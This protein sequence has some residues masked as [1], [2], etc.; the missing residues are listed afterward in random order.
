[1]LLSLHGA[2]PLPARLASRGLPTVLGGR[3]VGPVDP[4]SEFCWVDPDNAGG[5]RAAVAHLIAAGR[6]RIA[7][8]AGP[9]DMAVGIERLAGYRTALAAAGRSDG[10]AEL[11]VHGDFSEASGAAATAE[12]L[13]RVP[14]LDAIFAASDLMALGAVRALRQAGRA[15]PADVGVVG[16]DDSALAVQ[17]DPPLTTVHQPVEAMGRA[18][19]RTLC[20]LINGE[21]VSHVVLDTHLVLRASG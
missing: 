19:A 6:R 18:M 16:F 4:Q 10:A 21:Q 11:V 17:V 13:A 7:H 5:A 3:P 8:V 15:V 20:A 2:D 9:R 1:M 12:L 14:D